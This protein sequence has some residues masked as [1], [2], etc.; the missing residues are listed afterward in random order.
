MIGLFQIS[1]QDQSMAYLAQLFGYVGNVLPASGSTIL[2]AMFKT[3]NTTALVLGALMVVHTIV[4]GLIKTAHEGE[5]LGKQ[6]N[7]LW[8]PLRTV[9]GIAALF[10]TPSGYSVMQVAMMWFIVQGVGAADTLWNTVLNYVA[11][12]GSPYSSMSMP[13]IGIH[14][15]FQVLFQA[16]V[17]QAEAHRSDGDTFT[18]SGGG[19]AKYFYCSA[20]PNDNFC[21]LD[22]NG[23]LNITNMASSQVKYSGNYITYYM[24]PIKGTDASCGSLQFANPATY[25]DASSTTNNPTCQNTDSASQIA[26]AG[27]TA[28]VPAL[29]TVVNTMGQLAATIAEFDHIYMVF[30][31]INIPVASNT[32]AYI[33]AF[34]AGNNIPA[35]SC[36]LYNNTSSPFP[37]T[38]KDPSAPS[39][40]FPQLQ[41]SPGNGTT[42]PTNASADAAIN[43]YWQYAIAPI[44][45]NT[46]DVVGTNVNYYAGNITAAITKAKLAQP[47]NLNDWQTDA[48]KLGWLMA[49]AYYYNIAGMSNNAQAAALPPLSVTGNDPNGSKTSAMVNYRNNYDA[50]GNIL[51]AITKASSNTLSDSS[52]PAAQAASNTLN[53]AANGIVDNFEQELTGSTGGKSNPLIDAQGFGESLLITAQVAYPIFLIVSSYLLFLASVNGMGLGS[54]LTVSPAQAA[55]QFLIYALWAVFMLFCGWCFTFGGML[56]VY[57]PLIPYI[58]FTFGSIGWFL[59]TIEAMAAAPFVALGILSPNGQHELLGKAEPA[60]MILLNTFLRPTLMV[61]GMMAGMLLAPVV[62]QMINSGFNAVMGSIYSGSSHGPGPVELIIFITAYATLVVTSMNKCFALIYMIPE[63]VLT[64]IGGQASSAG[65]AES[66]Q[67]VKSSAEGAAGAVKSGAEK[68]GKTAHKGAAAMGKA[69]SGGGEAK[70]QSK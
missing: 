24:G 15:D 12:M 55:A 13:T 49:G 16:L 32:P 41:A 50:A 18:P 69:K 43:L 46:P 52:P 6:W 4:M 23:L 33:K 62:V 68:G 28:Q 36:C 21:Q 42:D 8:V 65:E 47:Q 64:W 56:A 40:G 2:G 9:M 45:G 66:L 22:A 30:N 67:G 53:S 39:G 44:L 1:S 63:K 35:T 60:V 59:A 27:I 58:I 61:M 10:P 3:L 25:R 29:Q 19:S 20:H 38:C 11:A 31:S 14:N 7:S 51:T 57:T 5:F 70:D 37:T 26:C 34:C 17:C 54:G 48:Q